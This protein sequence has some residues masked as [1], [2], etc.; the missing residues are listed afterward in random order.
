V[1]GV[2][3]QQV[4]VVDRGVGDVLGRGGGSDAAGAAE[5]L[6]G[7]RALGRLDTPHFDR[8]VRRGADHAV[9]VHGKD[10]LVHKRLV[11][12]KLLQRFPRLE[13]VNSADDKLFFDNCGRIFEKIKLH[14]QTK[15]SNSNS[16]ILNLPDC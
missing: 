6:E 7:G 4:D 3:G 5:R 15:K 11:A 14:F 9:S 2:L 16:I 1:L 8:S 13:T 12:P 10:G